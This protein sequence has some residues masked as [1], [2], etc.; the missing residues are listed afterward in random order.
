MLILVGRRHV[1]MTRN[2]GP[3]AWF[4]ERLTRPTRQNSSMLVFPRFFKDSKMKIGFGGL[5]SSQRSAIDAGCRFV[6]SR[7]KIAASIPV[8]IL[9]PYRSGIHNL[10]AGRNSGNASWIRVVTA[11]HRVARITWLGR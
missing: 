1:N 3:A 7:A 6:L 9:A 11:T 10:N 5:I 8:A 4:R 2:A